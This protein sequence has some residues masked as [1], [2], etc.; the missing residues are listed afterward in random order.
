MKTLTRKQ[1][2]NGGKRIIVS[3][4]GVS[5]V[6]GVGVSPLCFRLIESCVAPLRPASYYGSNLDL[7]P[8]SLTVQMTYQ[9]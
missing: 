8:V 6:D 5:L 4:I 2:R 3:R 1:G 7:K 9:L